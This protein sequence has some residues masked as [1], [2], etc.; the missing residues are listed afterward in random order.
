MK[1]PSALFALLSLVLV[2]CAQAEKSD[3]AQNDTAQAPDF[4]LQDLKGKRISLSDYRGKVLFLNFWATWCP[5]CRAEIPDFVEVYK[6]YK[7]KGME[8]IGL[9]V[10]EMSEEDL[11]AFVEKYEIDYPV[12]FATEKIVGDYEPGQY[13][14]TTIIIDKQGKIRHRYVGLI[15]K[16]ALIQYFQNLAREK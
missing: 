11:M 1:R 6:E 16:E 4:S 3:F 9:S 2:T 10:D 12:A 14:P 7:N 5:P 8:I 15:R 13:I